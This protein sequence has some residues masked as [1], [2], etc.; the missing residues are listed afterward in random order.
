[1]DRRFTSF[2][3]LRQAAWPSA[4]KILDHLNRRLGSI[5]S[6]AQL[7]GPTDG[8]GPLLVLIDGKPITVMFIEQPIPASELEE[9][10]RLE[11]QWP[12]VR[13]DASQH[14]AH[15]VVAPLDEPKTNSEAVT[16]AI[17]ATLLSA[18]LIEATDAIGVYWATGNKLTSA[19]QFLSQ[20]SG[21]PKKQIPLLAWLQLTFLNGPEA[22]SE[23]P[24]T[25]LVTSGLT[26]FIGREL[27]WQPDPMPPDRMAE[28][29]LSIAAYLITN[30]L[31]IADG[32]SMEIAP[33]ET[34]RAVYS[35]AGHRPGTLA[36]QLRLE[37]SVDTVDQMPPG[38]QKPL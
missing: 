2:V 35:D 6:S 25:A 18:A 29:V 26:P 17:F 24:S 23:R 30:G 13:H 37:R 10:I 12:S 15:M 38:N 28:R 31:V 14:A 27:E 5:G 3:L 16:L 20:A 34:I 21:I 33:G 22:T 19:Q 7:R 4:A 32:H 8:P 9:A 11:R 1:M 36:I